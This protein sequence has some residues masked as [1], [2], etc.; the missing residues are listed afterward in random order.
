MIVAILVW[1][2]DQPNDWDATLTTSLG[3]KS[4]ITSTMR[5]V[6]ISPPLQVNTKDITC[7]HSLLLRYLAKWSIL[8][9]I[10]SCFAAS[11]EMCK[12]CSLPTI[13]PFYQRDTSKGTLRA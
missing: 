8:E 10:P 5:G 3:H 9:L 1:L 4:S 12:H 11:Q 6:I 13:I 7:E 2:V